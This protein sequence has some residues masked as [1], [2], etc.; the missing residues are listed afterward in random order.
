MKKLLSLILAFLGMGIISLQ[1]QTSGLPSLGNYANATAVSGQITYVTPSSIPTNVVRVYATTNSNFNGLLSVNSTTGILRIFNPL[2]KGTYTITIK[3]FNSANV[4]TT[5]TLSITVLPPPCTNNYSF[6][7][8]PASAIVTSATGVAVA[9][10]NNDNN[11][12][13]VIT[14]DYGNNPSQNVIVYY[15]T[16]TGAIQSTYLLPHVPYTSMGQPWAVAIGDMNGDGLQDIVIGYWAYT[17]VSIYINNGNGS[18]TN[19]VNF[20]HADL[21]INT[22]QL[23]DM[24]VDG[25]LDIIVGKATIG[26]N[27][28]I[29]YGNG[30]GGILSSQ[31]ISTPLPVCVMVA[32]FNNDGLPDML[33]L[34]SNGVI[35]LWLAAT[36]TTYVASNLAT[37]TAPGASPYGQ[38]LAVSDFNNDNNMDFAVVHSSSIYKYHGN[39]SGGFTP[40]IH[41]PSSSKIIFT[42][43][44]NGDGTMDI[45]SGGS[46]SNSATIDFNQNG[47][48]DIASTTSGGFGNSVNNYSK[49][50]ISLEGNNLSISPGS[51]LTNAANNT[52]FGTTTIGSPLTQTFKISNTGNLQ[53]TVSGITISGTDASEFSFSGITFPLNIAPGGNA[54][55]QLTSLATVGG[56]KNA[57]VL[58]S[59]SDCDEGSYMFAIGAK[60]CTAINLSLASSSNSICLNDSV[61]L[62]ATS[63]ANVSWSPNIINGVAFFPSVTTTYT[64]TA[65][66]AFGCSLTATTSVQVE[67]CI[68]PT[69]ISLFI[70]GYYDGNNSMVPVL[71]N[72]GIGNSVSSADSI[73]IELRHPSTYSL[74]KT[75]PAEMPTN[76]MVNCLIHVTSGL[77]YIVIK[78]RNWIETWSSNPVSFNSTTVVYDFTNA[79]SKAY[80]NNQINMGNGV[81]ALYSGDINQDGSID[82]GDYILL[83]SDLIVGVFGY[84]NTDLNGDGTVDALDYILLD[85]NIIAGV[86][87]NTP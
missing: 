26:N 55:F 59:N 15:G 22:I 51:T 2:N 18:F 79:A 47:S 65:T 29:L 53:L 45:V 4:F 37:I 8:G 43:D 25:Y 6:G 5:T 13:Y 34:A 52:H 87:S 75:I 83:D 57:T 3:A 48:M 33:S 27:I 21:A 49:S 76:G 74:V 50:E 69:I 85:A 19:S 14:R 68:N 23:R 12:D 7:S 58:I 80:G 35:R 39:G 1:A 32:D 78:G 72:Q 70:Q 28:S 40:T 56:D 10:L 42:A 54:M 17:T 63:N 20:G 67:T 73:T 81:W 30:N 77:Y 82:A 66:D 84:M 31:T 71:L 44:F 16:S 41:A 9:D 62:T 36:S 86:G 38:L 46:T 60:I 64:A 11:I 61:Q 24:N